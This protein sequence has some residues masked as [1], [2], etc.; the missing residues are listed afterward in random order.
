MV[1]C[2]DCGFLTVRDKATG[3]LIEVIDDYRVSG[4]MPHMWAYDSVYNYPI[5]FVM[6]HG[7]MPEVENA[8]QQQFR[9]DAPSWSDYVLRVIT[10]DRKCPIESGLFGFTKYQQG[11]TPKEHR[12]MLDAQWK[13]DYEARRDADDKKWREDQELKAEQRHK[14]QMKSM[15]SIHRSEM[16]IVGGAVTFAILIITLISAAIEAGWFTKWFGLCG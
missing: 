5:C 16:W 12:E 15:R 2:A 8:A 7:L 3:Q 1:K 9:D 6:A 11:F 4:S 13:L 14:D 10:S